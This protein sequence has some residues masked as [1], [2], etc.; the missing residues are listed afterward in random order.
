M[1]AVSWNHDL[2]L[3]RKPKDMYVVVVRLSEDTPTKQDEV[4]PTRH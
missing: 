3:Q 4:S 1:R 2:V